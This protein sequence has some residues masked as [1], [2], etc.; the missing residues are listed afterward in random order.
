MQNNRKVVVIAGGASGIGRTTRVELANRGY[1]VACIDVNAEAG[2]QT[3]A[4]LNEITDAAFFQC[5][6]SKWT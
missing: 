2:N 4:E 3:V 5:D 6:L 1:R